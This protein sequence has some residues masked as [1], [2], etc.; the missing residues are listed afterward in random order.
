MLG[1]KD[2]G[3][4]DAQKA[5]ELGIC[6]ILEMAKGKGYCRLFGVTLKLITNGNPQL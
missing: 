2:F 3:C 5:C 1:N 6:K 4:S